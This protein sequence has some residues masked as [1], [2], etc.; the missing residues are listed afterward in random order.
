MEALLACSRNHIDCRGA[1]MYMTTFPC[2]NCAKHIIAAGIKDVYY[3][4]PYPK[5][6]ALQFYKREI[7]TKYSD[8]NKVRFLPF[9]GVGPRRYIDLFSMASS[10]SYKKMRKDSDGYRIPF[11]KATAYPRN[12]QNGMSYLEKELSAYLYFLQQ[13]DEHQAK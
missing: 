11:E 1:V 9:S 6:K 3:I 13:V 5:S 12:N 2:H 10:F 8:S 7:S 4:E